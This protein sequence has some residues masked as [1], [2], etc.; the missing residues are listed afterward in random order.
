MHPELHWLVLSHVDPTRLPKI[1]QDTMHLKALQEWAAAYDDKYQGFCKHMQLKI[2]RQEPWPCWVPPCVLSTRWW[3]EYS[4]RARLDCASWATN[5]NSARGVHFELGPPYKSVIEATEIWI[6]MAIVWIFMA[7]TV[8]HGLRLFNLQLQHS[9]QV[10]NSEMKYLWW[11]HLH[12][13]S[14]VVSKTG[15]GGAFSHA[16]LLRKKYLQNRWAFLRLRFLAGDASW[17]DSGC[18]VESIRVV[19]LRPENPSNSP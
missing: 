11:E 3:A 12:Q 9:G 17:Q 2:A 14:L 5:K 4:R 10:G 8:Q 16:L 7:I 19:S 1:F 15:S 13:S 18:S 6:F